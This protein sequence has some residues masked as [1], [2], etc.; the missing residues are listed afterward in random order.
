MRDPSGRD[1]LPQ[2]QQRGAHAGPVGLRPN[3]ALVLP[4]AV[5]G[6]QNIY[7]AMYAG[8]VSPQLGEAD[9]QI[10]AGDALGCLGGAHAQPVPTD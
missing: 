1:G 4:D 9:Q 8:G 2:P 7:K 6:I 10:V 3:P 5:K